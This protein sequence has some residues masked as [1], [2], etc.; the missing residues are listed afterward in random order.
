[1]KSPSKWRP[2]TFPRESTQMHDLK[3]KRI[4]IKPFDKRREKKRECC[5][6]Q[7]G[8]AVVKSEAPILIIESHS[9]S[10]DHRP[11]LSYPFAFVVN[12]PCIIFILKLIQF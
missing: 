8:W 7:A 1:M 5:E 12:L 4:D 3:K 6:I 10:L 2:N 11:I 9:K